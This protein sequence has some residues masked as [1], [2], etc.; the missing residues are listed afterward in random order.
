MCWFLRRWGPISESLVDVIEDAKMGVLQD[1]QQDGLRSLQKRCSVWVDNADRIIHLVMILHLD[2]RC[3]M[4]C[5]VAVNPRL[6]LNT[7]TTRVL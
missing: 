2:C 6:M 4:T 1:Q 3:R 5:H 7:M